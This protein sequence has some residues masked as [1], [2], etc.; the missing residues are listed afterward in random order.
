[1]STADI[2]FSCAGVHLD[3]WMAMKLT[4]PSEQMPNGMM[5]KSHIWKHKSHDWPFG[6][7]SRFVLLRVSSLFER[8]NLIFTNIEIISKQ[9]RRFYF[10]NCVSLAH[11]VLF[12]TNSKRQTPATWLTFITRSFGQET[13]MNKGLIYPTVQ[14]EWR[15]EFT[16]SIIHLCR[17]LCA[18]LL[19]IQQ[20]WQQHLNPRLQLLPSVQKRTLAS[21][22]QII[23]QKEHHHAW[24]HNCD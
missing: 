17:L 15:P 7:T 19:N 5:D 18:H 12:S 6:K 23:H 20:E 1:M 24:C 2:N 9:A 22:C 21:F 13:V 11:I 3:L 10:S 4:G 14:G 8:L 16:V